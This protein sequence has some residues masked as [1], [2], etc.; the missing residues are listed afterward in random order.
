MAQTARYCVQCLIARGICQKCDRDTVVVYYEFNDCD[1]RKRGI[2][3]GPNLPWTVSPQTP[4]H[5]EWHDPGALP[6]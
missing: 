3:A 2:K 4:P 6:M 1:A 5:A